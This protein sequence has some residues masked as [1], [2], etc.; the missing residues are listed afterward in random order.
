MG[1]LLMERGR[2]AADGAGE[3]CCAALTC[4]R[5]CDGELM[6]SLTAQPDPTAHSTRVDG[7]QW[8]R[9]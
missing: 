8:V 9:S 6:P 5:V 3:G 1:R 4:W 7:S 2:A